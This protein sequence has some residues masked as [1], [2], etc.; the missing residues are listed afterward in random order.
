MIFFSSPFPWIGWGVIPVASTQ[1]AVTNS[2]LS[3]SLPVKG[4]QCWGAQLPC[5][6]YFYPN[7]ASKEFI[8]FGFMPRYGYYFPRQ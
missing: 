8:L 4:D 3:V 7:L 6:P 2:G 5:T 1:I